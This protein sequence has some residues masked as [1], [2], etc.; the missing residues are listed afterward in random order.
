MATR[1]ISYEFDS[2][3]EAGGLR[4]VAPGVK[5]LRMPLPFALDH[6]NL[7]LLADGPGWAAVDSGLNGDPAIGVWRA[8]FAGPI[9]ARPLTRL[10]V[11]H[12]HPDHSGL[13]GWLCAELGIGLWMPRDEYLMCRVLAADRPP[14]PQTGID[15]YRAAGFS[16]RA[17][18]KYAER[19]GMFGRFVSPPPSSYRRLRD[20]E[21]IGIGSRDWEVVI[22]RGHSPEHACLF[23]AELNVVISGDQILPTI[24]SN[25]SL[26]PTEPDADPLDEWLN[27]CK[28]LKDRLPSDVLVLPAHG[29]PFRGVHVRLDQLIAEHEEGLAKLLDYCVEPKSAT[30]VFPA[31]FKTAIDGAKLMMATGESLAHLQYL[32]KR[33]ALTAEVGDDGVRR[34]QRTQ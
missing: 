2:V 26:W 11:T 7:W 3:P 18:E 20:G 21:R 8:L 12:M 15:F 9:K 29:K 10:L 1:R 24:S 6:I 30:E 4:E 31:L 13:A 14:A 28:N 32:L 16:E 34:Y 17:L 19:F 22:G 33:G 27:S 23:C 25:V 5:W